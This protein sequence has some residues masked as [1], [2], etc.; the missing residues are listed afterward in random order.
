MRGIPA[1]LLIPLLIILCTAFS[2]NAE[3]GSKKSVSSKKGQR[4]YSVEYYQKKKENYNKQLE[5]KNSRRHNQNNN[6]HHYKHH[7]HNKGSGYGFYY[8]SN[9]LKFGYQNYYSPYYKPYTYYG[10]HYKPYYSSPYRFYSYDRDYYDDIYEES[11]YDENY[12]YRDD[13][14]SR[15]DDYD[16]SQEIR[17]APEELNNQQYQDTDYQNYQHDDN[18]IDEDAE[19]QT[20]YKWTDSEGTEHYTNNLKKV[21]EEYRDTVEQAQVW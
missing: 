12:R 4:K 1:L 16:N 11:R 21:P 6:N 14:E 15:R 8:G 5:S 9:N 17:K 2:A 10:R 20:V 18:Y 3:S 7:K 13:F 19:P